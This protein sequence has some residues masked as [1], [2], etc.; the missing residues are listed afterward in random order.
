[1]EDKTFFI[2]IAMAIQALASIIGAIVLWTN[3]KIAIGCIV[4]L[5]GIISVIFTK[6]F[7]DIIE[8]LNSINLKL[9]K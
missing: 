8:L 6:G 1:M 3:E 9:S 2:R 7:A 5:V 4:V